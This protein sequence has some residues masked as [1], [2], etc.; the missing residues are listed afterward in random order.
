[1]ANARAQCVKIIPHWVISE[2]QWESHGF[3]HTHTDHPLS[4]VR[5]GYLSLLAPLY[6]FSCM[7]TGEWFYLP[8]TCVPMPISPAISFVLAKLRELPPKGTNMYLRR[9][10]HRRAESI[11]WLLLLVFSFFVC[12]YLYLPIKSFI[13]PMQ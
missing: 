8:W 1:M 4:C 9:A 5:Y 7:L 6:I 10:K 12:S 2:N 11:L 3:S 13:N